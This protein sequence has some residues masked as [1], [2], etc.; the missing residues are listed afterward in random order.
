M[1]VDVVLVAHFAFLAYLVAGG[2]LAWR[3]TWRWTIALHALAVGWGLAIVAFALNCP[4]TWAENWARGRA[5]EPEPTRGF[6]D[7]YLTGVIYPARYV[8]LVRIAV[9]LVVLVS[10]IGWYHRR[11]WYRRRPGRRERHEIAA[12]WTRDRAALDRDRAALD[13]ERAA[14][15]QRATASSTPSTTS[16]STASRNANSS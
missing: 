15:D 7:R 8:D 9:A 5:G 14:A 10:W 13:P 1:L 4:L 3:W 6:I 16:A 2:F 11:P 12:R